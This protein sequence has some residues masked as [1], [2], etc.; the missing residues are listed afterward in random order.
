L[1]GAGFAICQIAMKKFIFF[2]LILAASSTGC[3]GFWGVPAQAKPALAQEAFTALAEDLSQKVNFFRD[4]WQL[5]PDAEFF[6]G[7]T[8]DYLYWLKGQ[9]RGL[10]NAVQIKAKIQELRALPMIDVRDFI[11]GESDVDVVSHNKLVLDHARYGVKKID[12]ISPD[13]FDP[14]HELGKTELLQ[15]YL[16]VEKIRL[17][18]HGFIRQLQFGDGIQ[19]ILSG[20]ITVHF[21]PEDEFKKTYY[22]KLKINHPIL[23]VIRFIRVV[24]L[25]N[26]YEYGRGLPNEQVL[27]S[28]GPEDTEAVRQVIGKTLNDPGFADYV[29]EP[30]FLAWLNNSIEKAFRSY[31]NPNVAL[32]LFKEFGLDKLFAKYHNIVP[33]YQYLFAKPRDEDLIAQNLA[34][35]KVD[36]QL[37][38][39]D[40]KQAFPDLEFFHGT[41]YEES[42]R[43]ILLQGVIPSTGGSMGEGLYGVSKEQLK[44]ATNYAGGE[45]RVVKF[46]LKPTARVVDVTKDEVKPIYQRFTARHSVEEFCDA[47][48]I[49]VLAFSYSPKAFV[50][51][52]SEVLDRPQGYK[53]GFQTFG[54]LYEQAGQAISPEDVARILNGLE[55]PFFSTEEKIGVLR[56][57]PTALHRLD[58]LRPS[59]IASKKGW[60]KAEDRTFQFLSV[61]MALE[62]LAKLDVSDQASE[63]EETLKKVL[64]KNLRPLMRGRYETWLPAFLDSL[65]ESLQLTPEQ[66][67]T[68]TQKVLARTEMRAKFEVKR[69][70]IPLFKKHW[71]FPSLMGMAYYLSTLDYYSASDAVNTAI[72]TGYPASVALAIGS[73]WGIWKVKKH[74]KSMY[75]ESLAEEISKALGKTPRLSGDCERMLEAI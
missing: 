18:K 37:F 52:N 34:A 72:V 16:P 55:D 15:G 5:D 69:D 44:T 64:V 25:N 14:M 70:L 58:D 29:R 13:R 49:D 11:I 65:F 53:R 7:T 68:E 8:R 56:H 38:Y 6:G 26:Y 39:E 17:G 22:A 66:A 43:S 24:A 73:I 9:F 48:G 74:F 23:L 30:R 42:F 46:R 40:P 3:F 47:F 61:A 12:F 60:G 31:T 10:K 50:V 54:R 71:S 57:M 32:F 36:P 62:A 33:F 35:Y 59:V 21:A 1:C 2:L 75:A 28:I 45:N 51:K 20:K 27:S 4:A 19:E 63:S 41:R 67:R